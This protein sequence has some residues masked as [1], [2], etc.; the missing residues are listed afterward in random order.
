MVYFSEG[1]STSSNNLLNKKPARLFATWFMLNSSLA[2]SST[3]KMG[4]DTLLRSVGGPVPNY[5]ALNLEDRNSSQSLLWE[6]Q[7]QHNKMYGGII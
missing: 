4:G 3:Q 2:Y 1:N 5:T 6:P 7:M